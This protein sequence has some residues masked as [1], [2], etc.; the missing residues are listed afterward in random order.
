MKKTL[1][2]LLS[3]VLLLGLLPPAGAAGATQ[4]ID[5]Q[6]GGISLYLDGVQQTPKDANGN[7]VQPIVWNGTTYLPVR[8]LTNMLTDKTVTWDAPS[9]SIYLGDA[10]APDRT[11]APVPDVSLYLNMAGRD[12]MEV[13][14]S[15]MT[16][17]P[18]AECKE[19][20][21][22]EL[23]ALFSRE[24]YQFSSEGW[25]RSGGYAWHHFT[26][27]GSAQVDTVYRSQHAELC[28]GK[29]QKNGTFELEVKVGNG[30]VL[31]DPGIRTG[32]A[33]LQPKAETAP[34]PSLTPGQ[35]RIQALV[36]GIPIYLDGKLQ[37]P[38]DANGK[39]V[40]P[41]VWN[42]TTYLPVR[43][44]TNMLTDKEIFWH[45]ATKRIYLGEV[46]QE[47]LAQWTAIPDLGAFLG[48]E[49][50]D[51]YIGTG[52]S[53]QEYLCVGQD[54]EALEDEILA[55]LDR[56][57]FTLKFVRQNGEQF[58]Y[59]YTGGMPDVKDPG[60]LGRTNE[61]AAVLIQQHEDHFKIRYSY[62]NGLT[63]VDPGT[64]AGQTLTK[65]EAPRVI[66]SN[67]SSSD[68]SNSNSSSSSK[69]K[70]CNWCS[71]GRCRSCGGSGKERNWVA[72][73]REYIT[74]SCS[75]CHGTGK[76][77]WCRGTGKR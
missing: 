42:G 76:C 40:Q 39:Q 32:I 65:Y 68:S 77:S 74:Q 34:A 13:Y 19:E 24:R 36:G 53:G 38:T 43:A 18:P 3:F 10:P 33:A 55:L 73:T 17:Y 47:D 1:S 6:V 45:G 46:P 29:E 51:N 30:F 60:G 11:L 66:H 7:P 70:D 28:F 56:K 2:F 59:Q 58:Y 41:I 57:D 35:Q 8:A 27:T 67:D 14:G 48:V 44:L 49:A 71:N 9:N 31:E 64:R 23:V 4:T 26:Y 62:A 52:F 12:D 63:L 75:D 37:I 72:G 54:I 22:E 20:L 25:L 61:Y 16:L 21:Q 5:V 69:V 50:A 15:S